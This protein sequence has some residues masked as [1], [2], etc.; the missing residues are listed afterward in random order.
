MGTASGGFEGPT[1]GPAAAASLVLAG[2]GSATVGAHSSAIKA[3]AMGAAAIQRSPAV[4][5]NSGGGGD[6]P[7]HF[8]AIVVTT[9]L[10]QVRVGFWSLDSAES[11]AASLDNAAAP[12]VHDMMAH[13]GAAA[14]P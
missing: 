12:A 4:F 8:R 5:E 1:A 13:S 9:G 14:P 2:K 3:F 7:V 10:H 6:R 11:T